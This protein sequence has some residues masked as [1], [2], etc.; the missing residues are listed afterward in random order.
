MFPSPS[1]RK[2][3]R[4]V[5]SIADPTF[6]L[7]QF[8]RQ[9]E[10]EP[11]GP[12]MS[13]EDSAFENHL[14]FSSDA[15][16]L[17]ND[18]GWRMARA[19]VVAREGKW[20]YEV[21]IL[22]GQLPPSAKLA[23]SDDAHVRVG[24]ARREASLEAAPGFDAYGYGLRDSNGE[25]LHRSRPADFFPKGEHMLQGDV[26]GL[27]IDLPSI[28]LHRKVVE[29]SYNKAVDVSNLVGNQ[30]LDAT[31]IVRDRVPIRFK[32]QLYFESFEYSP[33]KELEEYAYPGPIFTA[34]SM[35]STVKPNP[36]HASIALRTLPFSAIKVYKNGKYMGE[37]F[38]DLLAFLPPASKPM[39]VP[40]ARE[41]VDDG[42]LGYFP[43]ISCFGGAAVEVN[44][45]PD[46]WFPPP[47]IVI[48]SEGGSTINGMLSNGHHTKA[49]ETIRPISERYDEQIAEDIL[50]DIID[51]AEIYGLAGGTA[52]ADTGGVDMGSASLGAVASRARATTTGGGAGV[53]GG[54]IQDIVQDE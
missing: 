21:K 32:G 51:E 5:P 47:D 13:F 39:A 3:Y 36:N 27:E 14:L 42:M 38:K 11:Y 22:N 53:V 6:P 2:G 35:T 20:Y 4:Y 15:K 1:N 26:I 19:N 9:T 45:G 24:W 46:F 40:N 30:G 25:K 18:R 41:G 33:T 54:E 29:G 37:A 16:G 52:V 17:T 50:A 12:R 28:Q 48:D 34:P 23:G 7:S 49:L 31:N 44:F 10:T 43:A 8:Y